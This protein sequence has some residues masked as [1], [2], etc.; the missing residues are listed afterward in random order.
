MLTSA[1]SS[2][3][4]VANLAN[5]SP[6]S[7]QIL[8]ELHYYYEES[9]DDKQATN[10]FIQDPLMAKFYSYYPEFVCIDIV[11]DVPELNQFLVLFI[12]VDSN[13]H[14]EIISV[15]LLKCGN[16]QGFVW[17]CDM[18]KKHNLCWTD[19][20]LILSD[21]S[22]DREIL[23]AAFPE[24][25]IF[26]SFFHCMKAFKKDL[27]SLDSAA[28]N[29][30]VNKTLQLFE[31]MMFVTS[32]SGYVELLKQMKQMNAQVFSLFKKKWHVK[33]DLW[34]LGLHTDSKI[35][36]KAFNTYLLSI[37]RKLKPVISSQE[38]LGNVIRN[39]HSAINKLRKEWFQQ[40]TKMLHSP[41]A[42]YLKIPVMEKYST[43]VTP[44]A[45][46]IIYEQL[47]KSEDIKIIRKIDRQSYYKVGESLAT[48]YSCSCNFHKFM[49][50]PC[51]HILAVRKNLT[52]TQFVQSV[53]PSWIFSNYSN[54]FFTL[55]SAH[56]HDQEESR[57]AEMRGRYE[58]Y[59][60]TCHELWGQIFNCGENVSQE[61]LEI[62][63]NILKAWKSDFEVTIIRFEKQN[64]S[65][66]DSSESLEN[67]PTDSFKELYGISINDIIESENE[68][69]DVSLCPDDNIELL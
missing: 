10:L 27:S 26:T 9:C 40:I 7:L 21:E 37:R 53:R 23:K 43:F 49:K 68:F 46:E 42:P 64:G 63:Q 29:Q 52:L 36:L 16:A 32:E 5:N 33:R 48:T 11:C 4:N 66:P 24:K 15:G 34:A 55:Y 41:S 13:G 8:S 62:F 60:R 44:F 50:L 22:C 31:K 69:M 1:R 61:R 47:K 6:E 17:I 28:V 56:L 14:C 51:C 67:L 18:F 58:E 39:L 38:T 19:I 20:E 12:G 54:T 2:A 35:F 30:D 65:F 57:A 59:V 25:L 45:S 3:S